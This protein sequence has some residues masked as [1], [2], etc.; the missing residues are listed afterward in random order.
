MAIFLDIFEHISDTSLWALDETGK[1]LE[2]NNY[3]SW[4]PI[5]KPTHI[6]QNGN[7]KGVNIIGATEIMNHFDFK[8]DIYPKGGK[9]NV[10]IC[11][12]HVIRF[13][14]KILSYDA[15]RGI[16]TTFI[17][18]D[19]AR[20]HRSEEI[21]QFVKKYKERLFLIFQPVYSPEL[22]PQENMWN[23]MK[24]FLAST[25]AYSNIDE[26]MDEVERFQSYVSKIPHDVKKRIC[27]RNF[28]K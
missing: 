8:Y 11:S 20:I 21:K 6:E 25:S 18:L 17:I 4:S 14:E 28:Y 7:R 13:I 26:L 22:N 5:G 24:S 16:Q 27:A 12:S 1:R 19:N 2:S 23:W 9:T 3:Y 10:N 15:Q